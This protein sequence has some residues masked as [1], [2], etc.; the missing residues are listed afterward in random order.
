MLK[1][2]KRSGF[3]LIELSVVIAIIAILIGFL[4]P[5]VQKVRDAAARMQCSNNLKQIGIASHNYQSAYG[6]LPPGYVGA[7][8]A[9]QDNL[10]AWSNGPYVGVMTILLPYI[11]QDN[12]FRSLQIPPISLNDPGLGYPNNHWFQWNPAAPAS[13]AYPNVTNYTL[14]KTKIKTYMCPSAPDSPGTNVVLGIA[15]IVPA[16]YTTVYTG[17]WYDDYVGVEVY[18]PFGTSHYLA[19]AGSGQ[20]TTYEGVFRNR[21][22]TKIE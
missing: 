1:R 17:L 5:A 14:A 22:N 19:S 16:P 2:A 8:T 4:L 11:E 18:K 13:P 15:T 7:S 20:N 21:S 6:T 9:D 3:T 12:L 10:S